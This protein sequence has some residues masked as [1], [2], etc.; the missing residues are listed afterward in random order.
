MKLPK[1][2][3]GEEIARLLERYG[4]QISRQ[5]GSH[6]RL[7]STMKGTEHHLTIPIHKT[8]KVGTLSSILSEVA[9]YLEK[10]KRSIIEE[11]FK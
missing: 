9:F 4:Y 6:T 3:S 11:L 5:T 10:D 7:T 1:D 2:I 8:L